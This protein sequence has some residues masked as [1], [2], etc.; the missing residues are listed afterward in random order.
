MYTVLARVLRFSLSFSFSLSISPGIR[1]HVRIY[2]TDDD[3]VIPLR[4]ESRARPSG[5]FPRNKE[6][7][8]YTV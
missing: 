4:N 5:E 3:D 6:G 7:K 1:I 2:S 8:R